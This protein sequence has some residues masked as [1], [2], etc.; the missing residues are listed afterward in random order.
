MN[1]L[2][3]DHFDRWVAAYSRSSAEDDPQAS[4]ALFAEDALYYES[5]FDAPVVGRPAIF[6]YWAA[7]AARLA[8]KR[9]T[10]EILALCGNLGIARWRSQFVV[11]A[12][13]T[14]MAPDCIFLVEFGVDGL[15]CRFREWW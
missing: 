10:H 4:A 8:E 9:A 7:G 2:T 13:G 11:K 1:S 12:T 14:A 6:E 5:H 3:G 15:C